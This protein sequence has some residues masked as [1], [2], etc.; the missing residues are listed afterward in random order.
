[1]RT[2]PTGVARDPTP[3]GPHSPGHDC[4]TEVYGHV[5]G[6]CVHVCVGGCAGRLQAH[7]TERPAAAALRAIEEWEQRTS[8]QHSPLR[9]SLEPDTS[10]AGTLRSNGVRPIEPGELARTQSVAAVAPSTAGQMPPC[11]GR[12]YVTVLY[13]RGLL[14]RSR[15]DGATVR[16]ELS[17]GGQVCDHALFLATISVLCSLCCGHHTSITPRDGGAAARRQ[18][19]WWG[20]RRRRPQAGADAAGEDARGGRPGV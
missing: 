6:A 20:R 18:P 12:L 1:M 10:D 2:A 19:P 9:L 8:P 16:V 11:D 3:Q 5:R 4:G 17:L 14:P 7:H 13:C 15:Y